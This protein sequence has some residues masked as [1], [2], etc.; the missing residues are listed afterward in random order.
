MESVDGKETPGRGE[1]TMCR[2]I[3][4]WEIFSGGLFFFFPWGI[5]VSV[6]ISS[7]SVDVW[8]Y[9]WQ[10]WETVVLEQWYVICTTG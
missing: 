6:W 10:I 8:Y 3:C 5:C 1:K 2:S 4:E 9:L 7:A